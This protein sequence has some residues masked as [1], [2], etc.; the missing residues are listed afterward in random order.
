MARRW[1]RVKS[2]LVLVE[3]HVMVRGLYA[4]AMRRAGYR[5]IERPN[6]F[7]LVELVRREHPLA[8][9]LDVSLPGESGFVACRA[10]KRDRAIAHTNVILMTAHS[11]LE[12]VRE[13]AE[14]GA[15]RFLRK[16]VPPIELFQAIERRI[17]LDALR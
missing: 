17:P 11:S 13:A 6:A 5:V 12:A 16:P 3:D 9:V 4:D 8:V 14:A 1:Y 15:D 2:T 7:G 10:I